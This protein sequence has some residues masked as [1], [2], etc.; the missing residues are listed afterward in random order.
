MHD[1]MTTKRQREIVIEFE[2]VQLIRKR[3]S[4][5]LEHCDRCNASSDFVDIATA[6]HLFGVTVQDLAQFVA[7]TS[8]H[9]KSTKPGITICVPSLLETMKQKQGNTQRLVGGVTELN[10][11]TGD[12]LIR[13][14]TI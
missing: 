7:G 2:K 9:W 12:G 3:A 5:T 6:A 1:L 14:L 4:T 8:V 13:K 11:E 10:D